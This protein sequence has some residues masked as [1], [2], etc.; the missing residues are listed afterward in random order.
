MLRLYIIY[1]KN[2][3]MV[4][5]I[6]IMVLAITI[7]VQNHEHEQQ[8]LQQPNC[9]VQ[10]IFIKLVIFKPFWRN[11]EVGFNITSTP[12][13]FLPNVFFLISLT[14]SWTKGFASIN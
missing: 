1:A 13:P 11:I 3:P 4:S 5:F 9:L 12:L 2:A 14:Q 8:Q 6:P 10:T 7:L